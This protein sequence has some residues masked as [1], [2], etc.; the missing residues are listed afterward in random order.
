MSITIEELSI[1]HCNKFWTKTAN[2]SDMEKLKIL[3]VTGG[4]PIYMEEIDIKQSAKKT[5]KPL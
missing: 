2:V 1:N 3:S 5:L 4:V